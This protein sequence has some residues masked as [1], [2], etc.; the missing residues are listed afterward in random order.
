M[1]SEKTLRL[2]EASGLKSDRSG[3]GTGLSSAV[4]A[5][6]VITLSAVFILAPLSSARAS[7][8]SSSLDR[9]E[10]VGSYNRKS[11]KSPKDFEGYWSFEEQVQYS[12]GEG[13]YAS[14]FHID[15]SPTARSYFAVRDGSG[16]LVESCYYDSAVT[17]SQDGFVITENMST[18]SGLDSGSFNCRLREPG[19]M[20]CEMLYQ[21]DRRQIQLYYHDD[22]SSLITRPTHRHPPMRSR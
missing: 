11:G 20:G 12:W 18:C 1:F 4:S 8:T 19:V 17:V 9:P 6:I 14:F 21:G 10:V 13:R 22:D 3:K 7:G 15:G 5:F 2:A 16:A